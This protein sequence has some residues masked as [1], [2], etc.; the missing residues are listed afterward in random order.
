M[1]ILNAMR[2]EQDEVGGWDPHLTW[3]DY[4]RAAMAEIW[5]AD[6]SAEELASLRLED[7]DSEARSVHLLSYSGK[8]IIYLDD[9]AWNALNAYL[10]IR[11]DA[12]CA[13]ES[14]GALFCDADGAPLTVERAYAM[15]PAATMRMG[16]GEANLFFTASNH[17]RH[18]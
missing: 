15:L 4:M 18:E 9:P 7:V 16:V 14:F 12:V 1:P 13:E 11:P 6:C 2:A 8:R 10:Q 3:D 5:A 17:E